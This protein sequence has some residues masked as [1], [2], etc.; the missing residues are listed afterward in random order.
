VRRCRARTT[1]RRSLHGEVIGRSPSVTPQRAAG[2]LR[3]PPQ[4][5]PA[6]HEASDPLLDE[7]GREHAG[8]DDRVRPD[9]ERPDWP[10][11]GR[12]PPHSC[13]GGAPDLHAGRPA[14]LTATGGLRAIAPE[15]SRA[16]GRRGP[17]LGAT[18][19][20]A[21]EF[22]W[23]LLSGS[24]SVDAGARRRRDCSSCRVGPAPHDAGPPSEPDVHLSMHP[25]QAS[26]GGLLAITPYVPFL[27]GRR[28]VR[29]STHPG[30][31]PRRLVCPLV[32]SWSSLSSSRF[33]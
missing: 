9:G 3:A 21:V 16:R 18:S 33:T 7:A 8:D 31:W 15:P 13:V 5:R 19:P 4:T 27:S 6:D 11:V 12:R 28:F 25:A 24:S 22:A 20:A 10:G 32:L 26:L 2:R 17:E 30:R 29:R 23:L 1:T 14:L